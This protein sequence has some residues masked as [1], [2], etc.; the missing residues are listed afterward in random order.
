MTTWETNDTPVQ[1]GHTPRDCVD[2]VCGTITVNKQLQLGRAK[3][4][5]EYRIISAKN[6]KSRVI[7]PAEFVMQRLRRHMEEQA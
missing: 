2:F 6:G 3:G 4:G 1:L 7:V 5:G